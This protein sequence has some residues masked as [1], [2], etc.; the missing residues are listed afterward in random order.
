MA[1][2]LESIFNVNFL[3]FLETMKAAEAPLLGI[4]LRY[5]ERNSL[6]ALPK[7]LWDVG[8]TLVVPVLSAILVGSIV[9]SIVQRLWR[10]F[11]PLR[12]SDRYNIAK[13]LYMR[14]R[15]QQA[16]KEWS[17][18]VEYG[19]AY[20]SRATH[21]L[22]MEG[23]PQK[24]IDILGTAKEQKV[25]IQIKPLELIRLDAQALKAGGNIA[26][27]DFN[28]RLAKQEHLGVTTL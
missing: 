22:Y 6:R 11:F 2:Q 27:I 19:P 1:T 28:A 16:L 26:M 4:L 13:K 10:I 9:S 14:G 25:L 20:L 12:D 3:L 7:V 23:N 17:R 24:A 15:K 21:A 8:T 5:I 18:L